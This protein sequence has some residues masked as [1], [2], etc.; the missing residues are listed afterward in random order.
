MHTASV[1]SP[2]SAEILSADPRDT[3]I[4]EMDHRI[5]NHLQ[6][7]ASYARNASKRRGLTAGELAEDLADKLCAIAGAHDALHQAGG[8]GFG[9][10]LPFLQTLAVPFLGSAHR[11]HIL[12]DP[13]LQLPAA[14]LAPVGMIV[15]EAISNAF[16]HAF[17]QGR[18]GDVWV[19]LWEERD[20]LHL[21]V[22]DNGIGMPDL[23]TDRRSG[24]GLIETLARQ[25]GGYARLGSTPFGGAEVSVVFSRNG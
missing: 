9:L 6:L 5:K 2:R 20:R 18:E 4:G 19:R 21:V 3:L 11:T 7:L 13:A 16:K 14:E 10:A 8:R 12:C 1:E 24:R 15:N 22:R 23:P 17:P 25:L